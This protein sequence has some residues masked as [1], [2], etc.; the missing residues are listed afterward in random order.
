MVRN[1]RGEAEIVVSAPRSYVC[2]AFTTECYA[3]MRGTQLCQEMNMHQVLF[4]GDAKQVVDGVKGCNSDQSWKDQLIDDIQVLMSAQA[5]WDICFVRRD[6]NKAT[7][8]ATKL[9]LH[10]ES[11]SV[12]IEDGP[13]EVMSVIQ[14]DKSCIL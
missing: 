5:G 14:F 1:F 8:M 11:E 4:E 12:W 9:G 6:G 3:L 10:L 7:H 2:S 13:Q